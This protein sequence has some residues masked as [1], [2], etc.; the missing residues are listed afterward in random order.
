[1]WCIEVILEFPLSF[2][3]MSPCSAYNVTD[4]WKQ[5]HKFLTPIVGMKASAP[6]A[7]CAAC[8][9]GHDLVRN[10]SLRL[11]LKL[12]RRALRGRGLS[13]SLSHDVGRWVGVDSVCGPG[14]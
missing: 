7:S 4:S 2:S 6:A 13:G 14:L 8:L 1:M 12:G 11:V 5:L 10:D 9:L 3:Y